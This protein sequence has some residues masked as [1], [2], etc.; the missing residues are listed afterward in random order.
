M[1]HSF[2]LEESQCQSSGLSPQFQLHPADKSFT[3]VNWVN[4]DLSSC[5]KSAKH[6]LSIPLRITFFFFWQQTK[7]KK[8]DRGGTAPR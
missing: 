1:T 8:L 7:G 4:D 5:R 2:T 6:F 3:V